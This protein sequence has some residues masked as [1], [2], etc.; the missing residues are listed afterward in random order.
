MKKNAVDYRVGQC[1]IPLTVEMVRTRYVIKS[2]NKKKVDKY[3]NIEHFSPQSS[4][5]RLRIVEVVFDNGVTLLKLQ[6]EYDEEQDFPLGCFNDSPAYFK[7]NGNLLNI[8]L[9]GTDKETRYK[10]WLQKG[11]PGP[12]K[13]GETRPFYYLEG[14]IGKTKQSQVQISADP[15]NVLSYDAIDSI[16]LWVIQ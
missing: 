11:E 2:A 15:L 7:P 4:A 6:E 12:Y 14:E 3:A 9:Y 1:L 5:D 10:N 8:D 13:L 16:T